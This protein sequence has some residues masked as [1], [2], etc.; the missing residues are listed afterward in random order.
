MSDESGSD[1]IDRE[2]DEEQQRQEEEAPAEDAEEDK[3]EEPKKP[4][5]PRKPKLDSARVLDTP[6]GIERVVRDFPMIKFS[7]KNSSLGNLDI[8]MTNFQVWAAQLYPYG[9][10]IHDF[11]TRVENELQP[12]TKRRKIYELRAR[13]L[14]ES[15]IFGPVPPTV[16]EL[17]AARAEENRLK[18][19]ER[20][21]LK[22]Q[23]K[24][25][26]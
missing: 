3:P 1:E 5:I 25:P 8:L 24:A 26:N 10:N 9:L 19:L 4:V 21:R 11:A 2:E 15:G 14:K 22:E 16:E 18:A 20:R 13:Y 17:A 7:D 6:N 23:Q 12:D